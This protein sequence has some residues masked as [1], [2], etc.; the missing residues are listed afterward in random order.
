MQEQKG[1]ERIVAKSKPT[2]VSHTAA[3]SLTVPGSSASNRPG[4]LRAPSQEGSNLIARCAGKPAAEGSNQNDAASSSQVWLTGAKLSERARKTRCCRHEP[5]SV[6]AE[7]L[8][9]NDEEHSKWPHN[10]RI[11]RAD[12]PH[13]E[14]FYA[15]LGHNGNVDVNSSIW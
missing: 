8:D 11:T 10:L 15:N 9:I 14:K 4:K 3:S 2:L 5:G 12:V 6:G 1:E 13:L 7:I